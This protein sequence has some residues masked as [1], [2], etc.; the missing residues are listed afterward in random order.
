MHS[1]PFDVSTRS[2]KVDSITLRREPKKQYLAKDLPSGESLQLKATNDCG[3][4]RS[5]FDTPLDDKND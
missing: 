1:T 4:W 3:R 2:A 5:V